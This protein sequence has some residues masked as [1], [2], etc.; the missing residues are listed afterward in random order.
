MTTCPNCGSAER[1]SSS[2]GWSC[3][4]SR[5]MKTAACDIIAELRRKIASLERFETYTH[6]R[7]DELGVPE[8]DSCFPATALVCRVGNRFDWVAKAMHL[9][10]DLADHQ[11]EGCDKLNAQI[12]RLY[13]TLKTARADNE[14]L[15]KALMSCTVELAHLIEQTSAHPHGS[16]VRAF[17]AAKALLN[18]E[19]PNSEG[20]E[21]Q[22]DPPVSVD[23]PATQV[24]VYLDTGV[25]YAYDVADAIKGREHAAA[26][27]KGG[28][29]HTAEGSND[30]EWFPPHRIDKV[31]VAGGGETSAYRDRARAT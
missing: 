12:L 31:K 2:W 6:H 7:L 10:N 25:V 11:A 9:A 27:I 15:R 8:P 1:S 29:R 18:Q 3:G 23:A 14:E 21:P 5:S 4:S 30:L 24:S 26:I 22:D 28:Y 16:V 19:A 13:E 20:P 17:A